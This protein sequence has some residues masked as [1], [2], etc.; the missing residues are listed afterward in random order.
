MA[1][2][3]SI[4]FAGGCFWGVE[5]FF[6]L[7]P[8][9][10]ATEAGYANGF[11]ED[12]SYKD[13]CSGATGFVEA[14]KVDYDGAR[15]SL[16]ELLGLF[17]NIVDPLSVN[18]QGNDI[19]PQYRTGIY[20]NDS[21][22]WPHVASSLARL[23]ESLG[24]PV[25]IEHG[26][27]KNF[28]PAEEY[29]QKYLDKNPG[30]YCHIPEMKFKLA[31]SYRPV[32]TRYSDLKKRLTRDQYEV[33]QKGATEAPFANEYFDH[34]EPGLYVDIVD[35]Q[36]LFLSA[37]KFESGCGWPSFSRPIDDSYLH[38]LP[39]NSLGRQRIEVRGQQSGSHLGH[40][41]PDGPAATGGLRYCINSASL[42]FVPK[43]KM[44][45]EGFGHLLPLL[46]AEEKKAQAK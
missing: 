27:L 26:E 29:H 31:S 37:H 17:Y 35:G 34:F 6:S 32:G 46:E 30:G 13:V 5:R 22:D 19:G 42:R 12:P 4:V 11:T 21:R 33:T 14:V 9:V 15:L 16:P 25:A 39:D 7:V 23:G 45:G 40:V 2:V 18:R 38:K 43:Y 36:P 41:F 20:S 24:R 8:G 1:E 44:A 3:K 28:F 10:L